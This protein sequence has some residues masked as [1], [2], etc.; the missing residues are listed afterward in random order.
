MAKTVIVEVNDSEYK[1]LEKRAE[2]NLMSVRELVSDIV[3]R[4]M[5]SYKES[6]EQ[7]K[8]TRVDDP[9]VNVF[10]RTRRGRK[11]GKKE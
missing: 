3:R 10:S 2:K 8:D 1:L 4:S 7:A 6:G 5:V 11:N 9:L